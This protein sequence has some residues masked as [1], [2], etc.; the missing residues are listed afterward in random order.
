MSKGKRGICGLFIMAIIASGCGQAQVPA[1]EKEIRLIDPVDDSAGWEAAARRDLYDAKVYSATVFPYT[2]EYTFSKDGVLD[3]FCVYP[4]QSV[5]R[6]SVLAYTDNSALEESIRK[7]EEE[8]L[9]MEEAFEEYRRETEEALIEPTGEVKQLKLIVENLQE[10]KPEEFLPEGSVSGGDA[11]LDPTGGSDTNGSAAE[12]DGERKNPAYLQWEEQY[13]KYEGN[14]RILAHNVDTIRL[15]L[16]QRIQLYELD[17]AFALQQLERMKSELA[18]G[19][20]KSSMKGSVVAANGEKGSLI[21]EKNPVIAVGDMEHKLLRC[22]YINKST[23][24]NAEDIYALIDGRRYEIVYQPMDSEEYS[25]RAALHETIYSTFELE[26]D[27]EETAGIAVGDFAVITVINDFRENVLSV[28]QSALHKDGTGWFVYLMEG[29]K[30]LAVSVETG[31]SDGVYTEILSGIREGDRVL[32]PEAAAAGE[33]KVTVEPGSFRSSFSGNGYLMYPSSGYVR[34]PVAY[35][36]VYFVEYM[37]AMYEHV[38]KGEVVAR[39]RVQ[40]DEVALERRLVRLQRLSERLAVLEQE[41]SEVNKKEIAAGKEEMDKLQELID[42]MKADFATTEVRA[43][44]SGI[45]IDM[46]YYRSEDILAADAELVE[47]ADEDTCYVI[48]ENRNQLLHYGN[49]VTVSYTNKEGMP[50]ITRGMVANLSEAGV[51][52]S[53]RSEYSLILLPTEAVGDMAAAVPDGNGWLMRVP[54]QVE[55]VTR[56]MNDV[57]VVPKAA[58]L[59]KEGRTYVLVAEQDGTVTARSFISGGYDASNYWVVEGLAAGTEVY[60]K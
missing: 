59:E 46:R 21:S 8:I 14:Y 2:E 47:I 9:E 35:G 34:N 10:Q 28:P 26:G 37:T 57:L 60:I 12:A 17:H 53:L 18:R 43:D 39:I 27:P 1:A 23:V 20:L 41:G 7:K 44:R 5:K 36:K 15:E 19:T 38:E 33:N 13:Y 30:S 4:G 11:E 3:Y 45:V 58:V 40:Q 52:S 49:E 54:V 31:M 42:E 56:E 32:V 55:A 6:G 48:L 29:E 51:G 16:E 50:G 22:Q 24:A 25:R